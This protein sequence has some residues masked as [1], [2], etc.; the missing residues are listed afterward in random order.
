M[1]PIFKNIFPRYFN[2]KMLQ[3]PAADNNRAPILDVLCKYL[4]QD[5]QGVC[6]EIASGTGQH[7]IHF[8]QYFKQATFQPSDI[9]QANIKSISAYTAHHRL[10]NVKP[11]IT[12]DITTPVTS[13]SEKI[14]PASC[15]VIYNANMVHIS[16]WETAI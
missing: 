16:P 13:W 15:D 7:V 4:P 11:P 9:D 12:I 10:S 14:S 1:S 8:A 6:L 3:A 5:F 2:L